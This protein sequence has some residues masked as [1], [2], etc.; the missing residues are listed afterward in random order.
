[1]K[2]YQI[3]MISF[4]LL[5]GLSACANENKVMVG[6]VSQEQLM[7]EEHFVLS[8]S[9]NLLSTE[10]INQIKLWPKGLHIDIYFGTWCHDSQREVP[11]LLNILKE[12]KEISSQLIALDYDKNDPQG[13]AKSKGIK[14]TP[15]FIVSIGNIELGRIIERP[16]QDLVSDI[17]EMVIAY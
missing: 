17:S 8:S 4:F 14:Y 1:M 3:L 2:Y 5:V 11:K 13:L 9:E 7:K 6:K 12:N 15:T 16:T 10:K